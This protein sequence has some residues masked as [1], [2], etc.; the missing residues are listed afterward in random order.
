MCSTRPQH[1]CVVPGAKTHVKNT[2]PRHVELTR[3]AG[4][5]GGGG[6]G[7]GGGGGR[8][9]ASSLRRMCSPQMFSASFGVIVSRRRPLALNNQNNP[10]Q[11]IL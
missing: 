3:R 9:S 6:E 10:F 11:K 5:G 4:E 8:E 7:E 2:E 1:Y